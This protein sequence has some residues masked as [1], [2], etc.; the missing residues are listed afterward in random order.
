MI[1][2]VTADMVGS[3]TLADRPAAQ[4]V[5]DA[6]IAEVERE[7][8][9][10]VRALRPTVGDEQQGIYPTIEAALTALL[11][12][13]LALPDGIECRFGI[14]VGEIGTI[15]AAAGAISEGP[16]WWA[17]R[18]AIDHVHSL[19]ERAVP[20]ARTWIV[21]APGASTETVRHVA[22][23]NAYALARD[24][25]V[26]AMNERA[27]R[28]TYGRCL[29]ARQSELAAAEGITQSAVSQALAG[30]GSAAIVHGF[31]LLRDQ[32]TVVGA[33]SSQS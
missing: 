24:D 8:P 9:L 14:G 11:L 16:G 4:R 22:S 15:P 17:A 12:L 21:A 32:T 7:L 5:L 1:A 26:G 6:T 31:T 10:A 27:R 19:A 13:Q 30:A 25:L 3:R 29:G 18:D 20:R 28:L 2:A 33:D 23:A